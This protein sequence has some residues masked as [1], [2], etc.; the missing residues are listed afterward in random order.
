MLR[1]APNPSFHPTFAGL[2]LSPRRPGES[3]AHRKSEVNNADSQSKVD[4]AEGRRERN[5]RV[6]NGLTL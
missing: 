3:A 4:L 5:L 6:A 2:R 1:A